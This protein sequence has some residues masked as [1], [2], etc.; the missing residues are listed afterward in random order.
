MVF[1]SKYALVWGLTPTMWEA[2]SSRHD[3]YLMLLRPRECC[4]YC[5][6]HNPTHLQ[7]LKCFIW[8]YQPDSGAVECFSD[9]V[10]PIWLLMFKR[11]I[12]NY[13]CNDYPFP[14]SVSVSSRNICGKRDIEKFRPGKNSLQELIGWFPCVSAFLTNHLM[15]P[16]VGGTGA[17]FVIF[18]R[19]SC[20]F[21]WPDT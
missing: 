18:L 20:T 17:A 10:E 8:C 3:F 1:K 16:S 19:W 13:W 6:L 4:V 12:R 2:V 5:T 15:P 11:P 7:F 21:D 14:Y 9:L